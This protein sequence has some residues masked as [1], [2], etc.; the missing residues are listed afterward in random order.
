MTCL[1]NIEHEC[2]F[3]HENVRLFEASGE[4]S[5]APRLALFHCRLADVTRR[6]AAARDGIFGISYYKVEIREL[7]PCVI[8]P[9][10]KHVPTKEGDQ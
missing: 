6:Y 9:P 1:H 5:A 7:L 2:S 3:E 8:F 10:T 4:R